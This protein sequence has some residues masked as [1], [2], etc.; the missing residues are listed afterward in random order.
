MRKDKEEWAAHRSCC[1]LAPHRVAR[2]PRTANPPLS[3][4]DKIIQFH[5]RA[6]AVIIRQAWPISASIK[7]RTEVV[8]VA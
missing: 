4:P 5:A 1:V 7:V 2:A 6:E 3:K 8:V